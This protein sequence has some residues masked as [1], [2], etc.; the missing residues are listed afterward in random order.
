[1]LYSSCCRR[2]QS[3][4]EGQ[5]S[6]QLAVIIMGGKWNAVPSGDFLFLPLPQ[7]ARRA[8]RRGTKVEERVNWPQMELS[9]LTVQGHAGGQDD[10]SF[11]PAAKHA[12]LTV[13]ATPGGD[14]FWDDLKMGRKKN[15][16]VVSVGTRPLPST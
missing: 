4:P 8:G 14:R 1:M 10:G 13:Q 6:T 12:G 15:L 2:M 11:L 7:L 9:A 3:A 16:F 5:L